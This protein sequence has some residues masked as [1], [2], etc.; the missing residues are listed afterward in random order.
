MEKKEQSKSVIYLN[1]YIR[2]LNEK[3]QKEEKVEDYE[4]ELNEK[5]GKGLTSPTSIHSKERARLLMEYIEHTNIQQL[6]R[7]NEERG[8]ILNLK[9]FLKSKRNQQVE[10]YFKL[11]KESI[12]KEGKID[13]VGRD[14]FILTNLKNRIWIPYYVIQSTNIVYGVPT[15]SN[16]HQHYLYDNNLR[17]KLIHQF[18]DTVRRR[19]ALKQQFFE[20]SLR[21]NLESWSQTWVTIYESDTKKHVGK[22]EHI[23]EKT[24]K[25][26]FFMGST[27]V[28]LKN[29]KLVET[30]RLLTLLRFSVQKIK[31]GFHVK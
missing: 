3:I 9:K 17:E 2:A 16:A 25:L 20:E 12:R 23:D 26:S 7:I 22:L 31:E 29:I 28:H 27:T 6:T 30:V 24:V 1:D 4:N 21:T 5:T 8:R 10:V 13:T 11:G 19:D 18:G 15:Y 14:F